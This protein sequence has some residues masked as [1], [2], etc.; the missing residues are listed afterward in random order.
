M[1]LEEKETIIKG[2]LGKTVG[3]H[4]PQQY[5][6]FTLNAYRVLKDGKRIVVDI[7]NGTDTITCN[8]VLLYI[9]GED[10]KIV[11]IYGENT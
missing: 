1:T 5:A 2:L 3:M 11:P 4:V 10:G 8:P 6:E 7:G 9:R